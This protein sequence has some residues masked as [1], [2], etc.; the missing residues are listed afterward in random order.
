MHSLQS[1]KQ[2]DVDAVED[3][4]TEE[5]V[6]NGRH[7]ESQLLKRLNSQKT[8]SLKELAV[9]YRRVMP[10]IIINGPHPLG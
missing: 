5:V 10:L 8:Y 3:L 4:I 7:V 9:M 2:V 6:S 1:K